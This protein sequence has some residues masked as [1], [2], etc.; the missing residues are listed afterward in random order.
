MRCLQLLDLVKDQV[1]TD[2]PRALD[3]AVRNTRLPRRTVENAAICGMYLCSLHYQFN[4]SAAGRAVTLM[5]RWSHS[6]AQSTDPLRYNNNTS[7]VAS[8]DLNRRDN[9]QVS[10][11]LATM[12][13]RVGC[14]RHLVALLIAVM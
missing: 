12:S 8:T 13:K 10:P 1:S 2:A 14:K 5:A 4:R 3:T 6:D 7:K 11:I 9:D